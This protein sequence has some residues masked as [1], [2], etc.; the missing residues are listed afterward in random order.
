MHQLQ[1]TSTAI[2]AAHLM[3]HCVEPHPLL[4]EIMKLETDIHVMVT[5]A[6]EP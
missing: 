2:K 3:L 4:L 1:R 6:A 5:S